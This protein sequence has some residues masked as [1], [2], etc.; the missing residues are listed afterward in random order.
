MITVEES[1]LVGG[2]GSAVLEAASD[3]GLNTSTITRLGIPY[4]FIEH[5]ERAELLDSINLSIDGL[6]RV[7]RNSSSNTGA[8]SDVAS[9][10]ST[11]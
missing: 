8:R 7:A 10:V 5:G 4:R 1:S 2:F 6:V 3:A 9:E 11:V